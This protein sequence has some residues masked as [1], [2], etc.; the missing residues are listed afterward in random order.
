MYLGANLLPEGLETGEFKIGGTAEFDELEI[1]PIIA[2]SGDTIPGLNGTPIFNI[3]QGGYIVNGIPSSVA[4]IICANF[5]S[6]NILMNALQTGTYSDYIITCFSVP[7]LAVSNF[8]NDAHKINAYNIPNIYVLDNNNYYNNQS[9][10]YKQ[11]VSTPNSLDGYTPRNQKLRTYPYLYVGFNPTNGTSKIYRYEDFENGTPSFNICSEVNPNPTIVFIPLNYRGQSGENLSDI[12][13]LTG[14]PTLSSKSDYF[15][16][17]LAQNSEIINL[18][19]Q[20]EEFNY[21]VGQLQNFVGGA[22]GLVGGLA[23]G[24]YGGA[25]TSVANTGLNAYKSSV[26]HDF[27]IKQQMA[28]IEKQKLLPDKV[29][30]SSSNA[31]LIGYDVVDKNIFTRYSIKRQFAERIDKYFDMYGYLTN[32]VKTPNL[33]NRPNWNYIKTIG[34]N[35]TANIPQ[36]DL[37]TIKNMFD[38]GI[39]LWHN[40]NT[41]LDYSQNN[42]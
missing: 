35:I 21:N 27:Y 34:C 37:Q 42:R 18:Q 1:V 17:W 40:P 11:L 29:S 10:T 32:K 8:L 7:K 15:N 2:Y 22:T 31:T 41:F 25:L 14:Y 16:S 9:K 4:F 39:T 23:S 6:Y 5:E 36:G 26:N 24:N 28:Q 38:S 33:K 13:A 20:Q 3:R 12:S 30:M 19:M